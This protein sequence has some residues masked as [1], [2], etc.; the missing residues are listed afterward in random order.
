[1]ILDLFLYQALAFMLMRLGILLVNGWL[2][3]RLSPL[4]P[5]PNS[6]KLSLKVSLL[7]PARNEAINLAETLPRLLAQPAAEILLLDDRSEDQTAALACALASSD[8]RFSLL[9]GQPLPGGWLGKNWA[10]HQ[11]AQ[12]ASGEVLVFTDADVYWEPGALEGLL[13]HL[14]RADLVSVFP[15]QR[16]HSLIERILVPLVD[17]ALLTGI[18]YPLIRSQSRHPLATAANGQVMVFSRAIYQACG[19]H[20]AVR[21]EVLED[22]RLGQAVKRVGG[23]LEL[24]LGDGLLSVRMYRSYA[25][26][27][28]G[29]G[30]N[31]P[32]FH[33]GNPLVLGISWVGH[34]VLYSGSW[35]LGL[36]NPLWWVVAGLGL[37]ERLLVNLKTHRE[38]WEV[39]LVPLAPFF[40]IPIYLQSLK[41][42]FTW[43]G[44]VYGRD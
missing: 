2:F 31:F 11:L 5:Q 37:L 26:I 4:G 10:C 25:A 32:S 42:R 20:Q 34:L 30:K 3:P 14:E 6:A 28:E 23:R 21:K 1:M 13:A 18:P 29:F 40:S 8:P 35:G 16:T 12:A 33:L 17:V 41:R 39:L 15:R 36:L 24:L 22:V 44:R 27:T 9:P 19:G 7:V 43:K 38:P